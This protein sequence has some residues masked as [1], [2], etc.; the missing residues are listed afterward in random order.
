MDYYYTHERRFKRETDCLGRLYPGIA[1]G[2]LYYIVVRGTK[3]TGRHRQLTLPPP[4]QIKE[5]SSRR[6][7][8]NKLGL[9]H[10]LRAPT[11]SKVT[12]S[13]A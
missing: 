2:L 10:S 13:T 12:G 8:R 4:K 1:G 6:G 11:R 5:A 9:R 3:A 7:C